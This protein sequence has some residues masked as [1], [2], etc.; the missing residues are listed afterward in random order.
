MIED[1][2]GDADGEANDG[3]TVVAIGGHS[4]LA[5]DQE[6]AVAN[7]FA[8]MRAAMR[9]VADRLERGEHLVLTHGNGPQVGFMQLRSEIA[10]DAVPKVP[11]DSLV[12]DSQGAMGYVIERALRDELR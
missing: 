12:A 4:L 5:L 8:V 7:Q 6:P 10:R 3:P 11:L 1:S 2:V 9:P